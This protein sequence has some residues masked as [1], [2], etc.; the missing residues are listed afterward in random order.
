MGLCIVVAA[1]LLACSD[2]GWTSPTTSTSE[3]TTVKPSTSTST[4]TTE[5]GDVRSELPLQPFAADS[6][7]NR[8]ISGDATYVDISDVTADPEK[9]ID[10]VGLDLVT[11]C[12][13]DA[14]APLVNIERGSGWKPEQRSVST[15]EVLYQ[16]H[17][18]PDAC[19]DLTINPISNGLFVLFDPETGTA[20]LGIGGWREPGGPL[21]N[22]AGDGHEAHGLNVFDGDGLIGYGRA[23][24]L[25]ALGGLL[26]AG[27]LD[28]GIFHAVA[29]NLPTGML[30]K[31]QHFVWPAR[32]ADGS[33]DIT[34]QGDNPA[35][36]MGTLLAIPA[37]V[38]VDS[39]TWQTPQ[40]RRLA[41]AAQQYG[42][43]RDTWWVPP[44]RWSDP[45]CY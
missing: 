39:L 28:N 4:R 37:D 27:D 20:D 45:G 22:S 16:R 13:T 29:V 10:S 2:G 23:S 5:A 32:A 42:W 36:A 3:G 17:L 44:P 11:L 21:L 18:A 8:R 43:Y 31:E 1:A 41:E 33:A 26:R 25:P 35:L 34:Y 9:V 38:D 12:S 24:L 14:S 7:W 40:G 15:G 19:T 6:I 30:S